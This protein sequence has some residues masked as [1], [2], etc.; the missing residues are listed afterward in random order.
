MGLDVLQGPACGPGKGRQGSHLV[1]DQIL[2]FSRGK[3]H[4]PPAEALQ[5]GE[6]GVGADA[7]IVFHRQGNGL[8]HDHE[9]TGME[10]AGDIGRSHIL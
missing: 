10:T 6:A 7:H 3:G 2:N 4:L 8:F 1:D 9:I 5:I